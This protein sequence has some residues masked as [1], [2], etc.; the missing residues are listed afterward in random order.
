M[1]YILTEVYCS[2]SELIPD[3]PGVEHPRQRDH[4][5]LQESRRGEQGAQGGQSR[6]LPERLLGD[7]RQR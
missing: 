3:N 6:S 4:R 1:T 5:A 2:K 7:R